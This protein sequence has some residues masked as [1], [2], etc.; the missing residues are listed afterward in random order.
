MVPLKTLSP[1]RPHPEVLGLGFENM[2][3]EGSTTI[4]P[5]ELWACEQGFS[6]LSVT[7]AFLEAGNRNPLQPMQVRGAPA[8]GY[9][10]HSPDSG[11]AAQPTS[12][13]FSGLATWRPCP[14]LTHCLPFLLVFYL[15]TYSPQKQLIPS[16]RD[17]LSLK[18]FIL[19]VLIQVLERGNL[20]GHWPALTDWLWVRCQLLVQSEGSQT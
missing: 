17:V 12:L 14:V 13:R 18:S 10:V 3:Y 16:S 4:A 19:Q 5:S 9:T 20:I 2:N 7:Q 1:T 15:L 6:L 8:Q 11:P